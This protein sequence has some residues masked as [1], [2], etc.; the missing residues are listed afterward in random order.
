VLS[1]KRVPRRTV[2]N[3]LGFSKA[4]VA[5]REAQSCLR[6]FVPPGESDQTSADWFDFGSGYSCA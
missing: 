6:R 5:L 1:Y 4:T 3:S 2:P